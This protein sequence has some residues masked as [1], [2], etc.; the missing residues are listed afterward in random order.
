[1]KVYLNIMIPLFLLQSGSIAV[2]VKWNI[3]SIYK[4]FLNILEVEN[5]LDLAEIQSKS[6]VK[7]DPNYSQRSK[8][9]RTILQ[10]SVQ[11]EFGLYSG[12]FVILL[13]ITILTSP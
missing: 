3:A 4:I 2:R 5:I 6:A 1:M 9:T 11:F 10:D 13:L 12:S 8:M 7:Q